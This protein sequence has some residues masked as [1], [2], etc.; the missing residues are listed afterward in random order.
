MINDA[1][2][3]L[4]DLIDAIKKLWDKIKVFFGAPTTNYYV[5]WEWF[6]TIC[7]TSGLSIMGDNYSDTSRGALG[8]QKDSYFDNMLWRLDSSDTVLPFPAK[9]GKIWCSTNPWICIFPGYLHWGSGQNKGANKVDWTAAD[10]GIETATG[11]ENWPEWDGHIGQ[12]LL[13]TDFIWTC[14]NESETINEFVLKV[15]EGVNECA[16]DKW[17]LKL[18]E[19][20]NDCSRIMVVD[21][22]TTNISREIPKLDVGTVNSIARDWGMSTDMD[23]SQKNQIMM[24]CHSK[25][26]G[27]QSTSKDQKVWRLYGQNITDTVVKQLEISPKCPP[28][29]KR[30]S[31]NCVEGSKESV[32]ESTT[33]QDLKDALQALSEDITE[34]S[35]DGASSVMKSYWQTIDKKDMQDDIE[36]TIPISFDMTIDGLAGLKWGHQFAIDQI[37]DAKILPKGH[38][39]MISDIAHS[40]DQKDWT[41]KITTRLILPREAGLTSYESAMGVASNYEPAIKPPKEKPPDGFEKE[42]VLEDEKI[43]EVCLQEVFDKK[44]HDWDPIYNFI[45][46]RRLGKDGSSSGKHT[47]LFLLWYQPH[48]SGEPVGEPQIKEWAGTTVPGHPSMKKGKKYPSAGGV[49]MLMV[50]QYKLSW[51]TAPHYGVVGKNDGKTK[52]WNIGGRQ[53]YGHLNSGGLPATRNDDGDYVWDDVKSSDL[54]GT[55]YNIHRGSHGLDIKTNWENISV[56]S[57]KTYSDNT[58]RTRSSYDTNGGS[59]GGWSTGCQVFESQRGMQEFTNTLRALLAA[60]SGKAQDYISYTLLTEEDVKDCGYQS[61]AGKYSENFM[62]EQ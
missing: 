14:Y 41:T 2:Q 7:V 16:G 45:G 8:V 58:G 35:V 10:Y 17:N 39:W 9:S 47:D 51:G 4:S 32:D 5:T 49:G 50:G 59:V 19:H 1:L 26:G 36:I 22:D 30:G 12:V 3:S 61:G 6:E 40:I 28:A 42:P 15:A 56:K 33:T 37:I 48:E 55:G 23:D 54:I 46:I 11:V 52:P 53:S 60:S 27:M 25:E 20:P 18:V 31:T 29:S 38:I 24:G 34:E 57:S 21:L 44:G 62:G 13:N 43:D